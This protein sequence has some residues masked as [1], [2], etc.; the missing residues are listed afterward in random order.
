MTDPDRS[1]VAAK[2]PRRITVHDKPFFANEQVVTTAPETENLTCIPRQKYELK[3]TRV[4]I[5]T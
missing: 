5:H 4:D 3:M 1:N 2:P